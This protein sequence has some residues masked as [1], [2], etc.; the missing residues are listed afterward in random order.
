VADAFIRLGPPM[1]YRIIPRPYRL[2]PK[3]LLVLQVIRS[4][5]GLDDTKIQRMTWGVSDQTGS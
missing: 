4:K 1:G 3:G 2:Y 5:N